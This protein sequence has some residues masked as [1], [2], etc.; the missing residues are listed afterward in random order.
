MNGIK[1]D[2]DIAFKITLTLSQKIYILISYMWLLCMSLLH[3]ILS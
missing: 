1:N 2:T 3:S